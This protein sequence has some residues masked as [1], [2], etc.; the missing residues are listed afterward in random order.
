[1]SKTK[2]L[3][4]SVVQQLT[5]LQKGSVTD[6]VS[7]RSMMMNSTGTSTW[8]GTSLLSTQPIHLLVHAEAG[9]LVDNILTLPTMNLNDGDL[10]IA[11]VE[12]ISGAALVP[13]AYPNLAVGEYAIVNK[14]S[15][16]TI[17]LSHKDHV[18][19]FQREGNRLL[20]PLHKSS[21]TIGQTLFPSTNP[22]EIYEVQAHD[23]AALTVPAVSPLIVDGYTVNVGEFV[24]YSGLTTNPG[25]YQLTSPSVL[26]Q[27]PFFSGSLTPSNADILKVSN[28]N[29]YGARVGI[30]DVA[31]PKWNFND[32]V[33][34]FD[35]TGNYWEE[36][37]PRFMA[38][39]T[40]TTGNVLLTLPAS[41]NGNIRI[42][43][44]IRSASGKRT[45]TLFVTNNTVTADHNDTN[46]SISDVG[47]V[48]DANI[49]GANVV[50]T[51]DVTGANGTIRYDVKRWSDNAGGPNGLPAFAPYVPQGNIKSAF[52]MS[53][54][55]LAE[56]NCLTPST[57]LGKT[58]LTL[59]FPYIMNMNAGTTAGHLEVI[60]DGQVLP[61][62]ISGSVTGAYYVEVNSTTIEFA[63]DYNATPI[64][65]EV[66]IN[67][68]IADV[69]AV[70]SYIIQSLLETV[71]GSAADVTAGVAGFTSIAAAVASA[72]AGGIITILRSYSGVENVV[73]SK[74]LT[75]Q[76][77]GKR[78]K[79]TG[80]L[81]FS[82]QY[83]L[84]KNIYVT[85]NISFTAPSIANIM[86][87]CWQDNAS[88]VSDA[89]TDNLYTVVG[90]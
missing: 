80:S 12:R 52:A 24:L 77:Q 34:H 40:G 18:I 48:F 56:I 37:S 53:D 50:I 62:F 20:I 83:C 29:S 1:M 15:L 41:S 27:V 2:I 22:I 8:T 35:V 60:V 47:V 71:V 23:P 17:V 31:G 65:L 67:Q 55:S 78:S 79:I 21:V 28:G 76:G 70:N 11:N 44:G 84:V 45:G 81:T 69:S 64:T 32:D 63:T 57:V 86:D 38:Y 87:D 7:D 89:G 43:Y 54:G 46:A 72:A 74:E 36:S 61:R 30:Y 82:S 75:I 59:N 6:G 9:L 42:E 33:R 19:L 90:V 66:R 25:V 58:R 39:N 14:N 16:S 51:Y 4:G 73:L 49:V 88:L 26:T 85:G 5:N 10:L 13:G 68:G 3:P